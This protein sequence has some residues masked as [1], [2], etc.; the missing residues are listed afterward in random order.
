MDDERVTE[1]NPRQVEK[2]SR[3]P[4]SL[5]DADI[6]YYVPAALTL[7]KLE[8]LDCTTEGPSEAFHRRFSPRTSGD[9]GSVE[10]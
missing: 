2:Q 5:I 8:F 6:D 4:E 10:S 7:D 1:S 9:V 3:F